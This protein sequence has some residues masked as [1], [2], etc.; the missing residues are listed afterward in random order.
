MKLKIF[1]AFHILVETVMVAGI[2]W[3][4]EIDLPIGKSKN[5]KKE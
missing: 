1:P 5:Q 4:N 2:F 3:D